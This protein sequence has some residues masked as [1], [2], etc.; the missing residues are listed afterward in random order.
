MPVENPTKIILKIS[1]AVLEILKLDKTSPLCE[2]RADNVTM[3]NDH[4]SSFIAT[5]IELFINFFVKLFSILKLNISSIKGYFFT[6]TTTIIT[7]NPNVCD[8]TVAIAAPLTPSSTTP[9]I[10]KE[11]TRIFVINEHVEAITGGKV[12]PISRRV[13]L[14]KTVPNNGINEK[15]TILK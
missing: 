11:L 9:L 2:Y 5:G 14:I 15:I 3:L 10:N 8:K 4:I 1:E 12:C 6:I 13:V 7:I